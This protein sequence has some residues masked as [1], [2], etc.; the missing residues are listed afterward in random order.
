MVQVIDCDARAGASF[1]TRPNSSLS[2]TSMEVNSKK[3]DF[4]TDESRNR[5]RLVIALWQDAERPPVNGNLIA[6]IQKELAKKLGSSVTESPAAMARVLADEGAD[7]RHPE[8]IEA[9]A[10]WREA[11][12][13][14]EAHKFADLEQ[15]SSR[16]PLSLK[17]AE[18]F[19]ATMEDRRLEYERTGDNSGLD[20]LRKT[21]IEVRRNAQAIGTNRNLDV[22]VRDEQA[23]VAEWLRVW[24]QTPLLFADWLEL[25]R[26][27]DEFRKRF[28]SETP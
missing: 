16:S 11:Q 6:N 3:S 10:E 15:F 2:G 5:R 7:L 12:I 22:K 26:R 24:L 4:A 28:R 20:I 23:E 21:A 8:I 13:K 17:D 14:R 19:V 18:L 25:R 27:S 1:P 9:D